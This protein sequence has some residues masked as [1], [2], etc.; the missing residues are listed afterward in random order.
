MAMVYTLPAGV[1]WPAGFI[2][3]GYILYQYITLIV[4]FTGNYLGFGKH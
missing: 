3:T 2:F 4:N 1:K